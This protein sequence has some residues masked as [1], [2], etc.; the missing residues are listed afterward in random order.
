[1]QLRE[2]RA[3]VSASLLAADFSCLGSEIKRIEQAGADMLHYDVMDGCFVPNISFGEVI[4]ESI[5]GLVTKPIDVHLMIVDPVRYVKDFAAA[6]ASSITVHAEAAEDI[7]PALKAVRETGCL[8]GISVKPSTPVEVITPYLDLI[9]IIL[10]MTVE[11]GF[12]GQSFMPEMLDKI[13][14]ARA[15]A[16]STDRHIYVE[17]DGG[18]NGETAALVKERG[19][20]LLVSGSYLFGAKDPAAAVAGLKA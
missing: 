16:D 14:A 19:A 1:M 4:L 10:I 11:P 13:A 9:D 7:V 5:K 17:V 15:L 18:I 6:G 20:D 8:A 3:S 12:G 2:N